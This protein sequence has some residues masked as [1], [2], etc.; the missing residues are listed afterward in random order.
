[1][2]TKQIMIARALTLMSLAAVLA[3]AAPA[4]AGDDGGCGWPRDRKGWL[5]GFNT[6]WGTSTYGATI[7]KRTISDEGFGGGM[8]GLRVGYAFSNAFAVSLEGYG[9]GSD[10]GDDDW[11]MGAGF[12]TATWYPGG[13]GFFVRGGLGLGGGEL[14][15][16]ET[17]E[18]LDFGAEAAGLISLG[19][20]WQVTRKFALGLSVDGFGFDLGGASGLDDDFAGVGGMTIQFNWYL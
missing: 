12:A 10:E 3:T 18:M 14:L 6:G 4:R 8:G 9:F 1:M 5:V 15:M 7:G 19:Y 16:R 2:K 13:G 11:G 17:G 20:E